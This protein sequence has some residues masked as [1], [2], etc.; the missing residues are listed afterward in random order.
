MQPSDSDLPEG[1]TINLA[2]LGSGTTNSSGA[3]S[4]ALNTSAVAP[5]DLGD[6]GDGTPDAPGGGGWA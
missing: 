2:E 3:F 6:A 4:A 1:T 5:S